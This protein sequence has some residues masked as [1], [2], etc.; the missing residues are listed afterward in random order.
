MGKKHALIV[1]GGVISAMAATVQVASADPEGGNFGECG[2]LP[3]AS[4]CYIE[5]PGFPGGTVM[6]DVDVI[7]PP[8]GEALPNRFYL[9]APGQP[10]ACQVDFTA[11]DPMRTWQ[12]ATLNAGTLQLNV[13]KRD[14]ESV[15]MALR[16]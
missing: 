4:Q 8:G 10:S 3:V 2:V 13:T 7:G 1:L 5:A 6:I 12:C 9:S 16:W 14:N 15:K 11:G